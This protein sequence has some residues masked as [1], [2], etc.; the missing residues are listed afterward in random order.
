MLSKI[1]ITDKG[2][3]KL[4]VGNERLLT[5]SSP[6]LHKS[7]TVKDISCC[8]HISCVTADLFWVNGPCGFNTLVL[9][10]TSGNTLHRYNMTTLVADYTEMLII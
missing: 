3:R 7:V 9:K 8:D 1:Q 10:D 5:L 2:K 6:L 4:K